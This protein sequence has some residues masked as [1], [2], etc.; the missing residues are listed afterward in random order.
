M[1]IHASLNE[2]DLPTKQCTG[3]VARVLNTTL[4]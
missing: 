2:P 3:V 4:C 1:S